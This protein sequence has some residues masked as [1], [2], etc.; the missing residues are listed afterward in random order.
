MVSELSAAAALALI[1]STATLVKRL[2]NM[3]FPKMNIYVIEPHLLS[4]VES[5]LTATA[6]N[7]TTVDDFTATRQR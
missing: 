6:I 1:P 3:V 2:L 7:Q 5:S 4:R